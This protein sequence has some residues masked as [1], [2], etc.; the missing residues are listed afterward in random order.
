MR[1]ISKDLET[2]LKEENLTVEDL[3]FMW[4]FC[5]EFGHRVISNL[6]NNNINWKDLN[7]VAIKSL[8]NAYNETLKELFDEQ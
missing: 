4:D 6:K 7:I 3:N 1:K 8:P 5:A 2:W